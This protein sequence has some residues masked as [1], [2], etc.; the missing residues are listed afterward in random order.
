MHF[1]YTNHVGLLLLFFG[2]IFIIAE[3]FVFS[4]GILGFTGFLAFMF[5]LLILIDVNS[6]NPK[7]AI[8]MVVIVGI[9]LA[10]FLTIIIYLAVKARKKPIVSGR[11]NLVGSTVTVIL[12]ESGMAKVKH[13]GETWRITADSPLQEGQ[14]VKIVA[15]T[16]NML[17]VVKPSQKGE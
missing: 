17:L 12:D 10:S 5:G 8:P 15:I 11:E 16:D 1:I 4:F 6:Y 7:V 2:L 13:R 3:A 9:I 14:N